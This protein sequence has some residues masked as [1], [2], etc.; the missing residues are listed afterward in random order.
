R[1]TS[2]IHP[3]NDPLGSGYQYMQARMV[4]GSGQLGGTGILALLTSGANLPEQHTDFI[5]AVIAQQGGF[6]GASSLLLLYFLL[7]Y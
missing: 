4:V 1:L 3:E 6:I 7:F 2:F 5:F